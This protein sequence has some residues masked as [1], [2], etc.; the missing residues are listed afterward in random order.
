[1]RNIEDLERRALV[2]GYDVQRDSLGGRERGMCGVLDYGAE[3][4]EGGL[5]EEFDGDTDGWGGH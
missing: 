1:M 2:R 3:L 4:G 5:S